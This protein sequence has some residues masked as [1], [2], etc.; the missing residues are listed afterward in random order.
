MRRE[1][2]RVTDE[3]CNGMALLEGFLEDEAAVAATGARD[4]D[5]HVF[6]FFVEDGME[7]WCSF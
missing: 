3:G 2:V 7:F 4:E 1:G 5:V 6:F